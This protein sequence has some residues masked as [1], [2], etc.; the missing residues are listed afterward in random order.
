MTFP[1][2]RRS[3]H[4]LFYLLILLMITIMIIMMFVSSS[5]SFPD[6]PLFSSVNTVLLFRCLFILVLWNQKEEEEGWQ[7]NVFPCSHTHTHTDLLLDRERVPLL[8]LTL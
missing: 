5:H 3:L 8:C 1:A 7:W 6:S 4:Q 2:Y